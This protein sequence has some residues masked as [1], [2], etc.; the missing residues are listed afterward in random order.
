MAETSTKLD[1]NLKRI[2]TAKKLLRDAISRKSE[3]HRIYVSGIENG[4]RNPT[5]AA[6]QN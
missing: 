2:G 1:K 5:L 6:I 3:V 4:K